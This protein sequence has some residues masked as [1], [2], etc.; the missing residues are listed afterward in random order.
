M[1]T[2][3]HGK[4]N[5]LKCEYGPHRPLVFVM[6]TLLWIVSIKIYTTMIGH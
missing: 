5:I 3:L 1:I 4:I 6:L 2:S